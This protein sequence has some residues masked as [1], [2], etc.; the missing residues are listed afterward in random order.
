[1]KKPTQESQKRHHH[2]LV[3]GE[4]TFGIKD[5]NGNVEQNLVKLN[6]IVYSEDKLFRKK[7]IAKAQQT[8]Q[9]QL[10]NRIGAEKFVKDVEV[11]NVVMLGIFSLGH[12][13]RDEFNE[14]PEGMQLV[15]KGEADKILNQTYG[16]A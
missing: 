13:T 10:V 15:E 9:M 12:M 4:I 11:S 7:E 8:L 3:A 6:C 16:T 5:E 14:T 1:M 2:W